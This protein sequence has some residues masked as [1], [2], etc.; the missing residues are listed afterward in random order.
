[1][2]V[3]YRWLVHQTTDRDAPLARIPLNGSVCRY[4]KHALLARI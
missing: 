1:M 2:G 4:E 3:G